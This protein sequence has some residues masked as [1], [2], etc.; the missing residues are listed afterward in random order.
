MNEVSELFTWW[1]SIEKLISRDFLS[2]F[3]LHFPF[4]LDFPTLIFAFGRHSFIRRVH[5]RLILECPLKLSES[6]SNWINKVL[7]AGGFW[8]ECVD[9]SD[10]YNCARFCG[11]AMC[12]LLGN[13]SPANYDFMTFW[14]FRLHFC[15]R[16]IALH[17]KFA[18]VGNARKTEANLLLFFSV[19]LV[20]RQIH[21]LPHSC[22]HRHS[23]IALSEM[24]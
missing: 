24:L 18:N 14:F 12:M 21:H 1:K 16:I 10:Y 20:A 2:R 3:Y 9:K 6:H 19:V 7:C 8:N 15:P 23:K 11:R 4:W 22:G 5:T 13:K 17:N